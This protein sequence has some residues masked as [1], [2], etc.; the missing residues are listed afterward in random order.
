M[1]AKNLSEKVEMSTDWLLKDRKKKVNAVLRT[2]P[3]IRDIGKTAFSNTSLQ[4]L[5]FLRYS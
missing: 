3:N 2:T 1:P 4:N 5:Y